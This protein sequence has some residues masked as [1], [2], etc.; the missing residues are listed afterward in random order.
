MPREVVAGYQSY[1]PA[2]LRQ[3]MRSPGGDLAALGPAGRPGAPEPK[4]FVRCASLGLR[5][6]LKVR[7]SHS[8]SPG[9]EGGTGNAVLPGVG[10]R[11]AAGR[12]AARAGQQG[13]DPAA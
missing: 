1:R 5:T 13:R 11:P 4:E 8:S 10:D 7:E 9:P 2:G 3:P 12:S 6:N